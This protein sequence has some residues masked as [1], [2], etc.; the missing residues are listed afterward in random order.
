MYE[1]WTA[2]AGFAINLVDLFKDS[3]AELSFLFSFFEKSELNHG[4][5]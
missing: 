2:L 4:S 5:R 1:R 3:V